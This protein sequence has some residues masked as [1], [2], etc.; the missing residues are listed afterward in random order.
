MGGRQVDPTRLVA[1]PS[2]PE[3][4]VADSTLGR[5]INCHELDNE[6]ELLLRSTFEASSESTWTHTAEHGFARV[7][8][9]RTLP[10]PLASPLYHHQLH[11][12]YSLYVVVKLAIRIERSSKGDDTGFASIF[13]WPNAPKKRRIEKC[14]QR[15]RY[16]DT[17]L[18]GLANT[19]PATPRAAAARDAR[20]ILRTAAT[21]GAGPIRRKTR[22]AC[23][24]DCR[25]SKPSHF[26]GA[27][28]IPWGR[29]AKPCRQ[30]RLD[31]SGRV[32][33]DPL[34]R[35]FAIQPVP[36]TPPPHSPM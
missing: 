21:R 25:G 28:W 20:G 32:H 31:S 5:A 1:A 35:W 26:V 23:R 10:P 2:S 27:L 14:C 36:A 19:H 12:L 17:N 29:R 18:V 3:F 15:P 16:G 30:N 8:E 33:T 6:P 24:T 4:D 7:A 34:S 11:S 9:L 13:R 22:C